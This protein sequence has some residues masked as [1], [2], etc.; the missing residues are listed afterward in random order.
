MN[1]EIFIAFLSTVLVFMITPGPSHLLMLSNSIQNGFKKSLATAIGDLSANFLQML[2]ASLGLVS[3]I[4]NAQEFFIL[5][6]WAGVAYLVYV[7]LKLFFTESP[8]N[9][10]GSKQQR[11]SSSLFWQG[12]IT[13]AVNPKAVIFFAALF[14]QFINPTEPLLIQ[15]VILSITYLVIDGLFLSFYGK[16]SEVIAKK[17]SNSYGKYFNKVCGTFII[18]AAII[19]GLKDIQA[20]TKA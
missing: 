9:V 6:K 12:F 2:V 5:V 8:H 7:G 17:F 10:K 13:S 16:F 19:L 18:G 4:Q 3:L 11:T 15:F 20:D 1:I 14:P